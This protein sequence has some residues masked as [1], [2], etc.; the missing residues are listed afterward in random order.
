MD[1]ERGRFVEEQD[2][3]RWMKR[4]GVGETVKVKDVEF[5]VMEIG[6]RRLVLKLLSARDREVAHLAAEARH[7]AIRRELQEEN[8][9]NIFRDDRE[10]NRK[11]GQSGQA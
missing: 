10:K 1:T 7:R 6:D 3:E 8:R 2:A 9:R 4:L 11:R 5:E